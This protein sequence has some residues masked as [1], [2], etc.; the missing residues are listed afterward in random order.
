MRKITKGGLAALL[1]LSAGSVYAENNFHVSLSAGWSEV[2]TEI[3]EGAGYSLDEEDTALGI[4]LGYMFTE[5]FGIEV[6]YHDVGEASITTT[7]PFSGTAYGSTVTIEPGSQ[8]SVEGSGFTVG[9][10]ALMPVT[11]Q[12]DLYVKGG[13]YFWDTEYTASGTVTIDG[14]PYTGSASVD[15]DGADEYLGVGGTYSINEQTAIGAEWVRY[16]IDDVDVDT[17]NAVLKFNF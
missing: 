15:D 3:P 8:L 7:A 6:G 9:L 10:I 14:T 11:E 5:N 4:D 17:V 12:V 2:D 13:G 16:G 1:A